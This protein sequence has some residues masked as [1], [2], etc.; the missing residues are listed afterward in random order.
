MHLI[1][2]TQIPPTCF[3]ALEGED[4]NKSKREVI[5]PVALVIKQYLVS[6]M[7]KWLGTTMR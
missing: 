7:T 5:H 2:Q 6:P 3:A 1:S 4:G